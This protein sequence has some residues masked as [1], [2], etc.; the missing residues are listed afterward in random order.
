MHAKG[1]ADSTEKKRKEAEDRLASIAYA[2]GP[3][4]VLGG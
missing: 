1:R 3:T 4:V 2:Q